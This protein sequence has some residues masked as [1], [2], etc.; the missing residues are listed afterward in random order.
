MASRY[1][2]PQVNVQDLPLLHKNLGPEH[3]TIRVLYHH[4]MVP[5]GH[6]YGAI[7]PT[8]V[9]VDDA[10]LGTINRH[11]PPFDQVPFPF[12]NKVKVKLEAGQ[13]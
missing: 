6:G 7:P 13:D 10:D 5:G 9:P 4:L 11:N 12:G 2:E 8:I 1:R 3:P